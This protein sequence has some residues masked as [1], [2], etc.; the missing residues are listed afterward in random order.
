[1]GDVQQVAFM[2]GWREGGEGGIGGLGGWYF[3]EGNK[4]KFWRQRALPLSCVSPRRHTAG[5]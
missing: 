4:S 3:Y 1:M 2:T 5:L